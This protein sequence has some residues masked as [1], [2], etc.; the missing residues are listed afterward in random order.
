MLG[1]KF[2]IIISNLISIK[3]ILELEFALTEFGD[4]TAGKK[5]ANASRELFREMIYKIF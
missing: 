5:I 3:L 2:L 1:F 4:D